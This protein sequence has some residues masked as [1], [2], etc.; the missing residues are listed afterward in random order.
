M[1]SIASELYLKK[2]KKKIYDTIDFVKQHESSIKPEIREK[3]ISD[4]FSVEID[5]E[6]S[7]LFLNF[8]KKEDI[9][10]YNR[11]VYSVESINDKHIFYHFDNYGRLHTN[12]TILKNTNFK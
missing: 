10:I 11:N 7:I 2:Y 9:D 5:L 12:F 1:Y 6:R 4:L 8:L 3:L